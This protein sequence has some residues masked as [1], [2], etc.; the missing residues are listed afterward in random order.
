[1]GSSGLEDT[2]YV[3]DEATFLRTDEFF[4][5]SRERLNRIA[6][7]HHLPRVLRAGGGGASARSASEMDVRGSDLH[8]PH[9]KSRRNNPRGSTTS[10]TTAS[11][12]DSDGTSS[13]KSA[14]EMEED[15][16]F[17]ILRET[18][19]VHKYVASRGQRE[20]EEDI[21]EVLP[22]TVIMVKSK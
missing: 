18:A 5:V 2:W 12:A 8:H 1:M 17:Q 13:N 22:S 3:V 9:C 16:S 11:A 19:T 14:A 4:K 7:C 20:R 21:Y 6:K 10:T 15:L